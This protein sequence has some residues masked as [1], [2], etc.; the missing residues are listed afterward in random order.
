MAGTE[1]PM[2]FAPPGVSAVKNWFRGLMALLVGRD[3]TPTPQRTDWRGCPVGDHT[4]GAIPP[5]SLPGDDLN[6]TLRPPS[7]AEAPGRAAG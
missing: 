7:S 4:G 2:R 3:R 5:V 1:T 6:A